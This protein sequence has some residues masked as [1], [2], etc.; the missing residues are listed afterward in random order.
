LHTTSALAMRTKK[1]R[2]DKDVK[3]KI[4]FVDSEESDDAEQ[5]EPGSKEPATKAK[6]LPSPKKDECKRLKEQSPVKKVEND[7]FKA[8]EEQ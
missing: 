7:P 8:K 5:R 1:A 3:S 4:I 6:P 2:K